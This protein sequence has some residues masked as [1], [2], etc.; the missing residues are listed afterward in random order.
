MTKF[1]F[2]ATLA[3]LVST[4]AAADSFGKPCTAEPKDKWL[5]LDAIEKIVVSHGYTV[6]KARMKGTCAEIYTKDAKGAKTELFIDP[7]TGNPAGSDW[8]KGP[9]N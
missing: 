4:P 9:T 2:A 1:I 7:A 8:T 5:T 3:A 6:T